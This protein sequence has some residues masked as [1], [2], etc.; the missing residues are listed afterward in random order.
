M[1]YTVKVKR[2]KNN[3]RSAP[4]LSSDAPSEVRIETSRNSNF[5]GIKF[6]EGSRKIAFESYCRNNGNF[7]ATRREIKTLDLL[8]DRVP[9]LRVLRTWAVDDH[10]DVIKDMVDEGLVDL[11]KF[12]EDPDLQKAIEGD[13]TYFLVLM[14][15][16]SRVIGDMLRKN[17][18]LMPKNSRDAV[19]VLK[20]IT[21][22]LRF[23]EDRIASK[24]GTKPVGVSGDD[25]GDEKIVDFVT[26]VKKKHPDKVMSIS[27][28]AREMVRDQNS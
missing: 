25:N 20:S 15:I 21:E 23:L 5:T 9:S 8:G 13:E 10:W 17:S 6:P 28:L 2:R 7:S 19:T 22:E 12:K 11:L 26:A 18:T 24:G 3:R 16:K 14:K 1:S 4:L 27:E